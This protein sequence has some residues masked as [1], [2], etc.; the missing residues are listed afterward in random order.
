MYMV[1]KLW[2]AMRGMLQAYGGHDIKRHLWN[3]EFS[4]GRW[5]C[6][7]TSSDDRVYSYVEK[8]ANNGSILDLGCGSGSTGNELD[9]SAYREY[10][11]VD[12][13]DVAIDKAR[14]RSEANGRTSKNFYFQSDIASFVPSKK[15]DVILL[16]DSIYYLP[17]TKIYAVL[18]RYSSY[19][20]DSGVFIVRMHDYVSGNY[21]TIVD[22][23]ETNFT[24]HEK[25]ME[26]QS[27]M[28]IIVFREK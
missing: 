1:Q 25:Y 4:K 15:F 17:G 18:H 20:N 14:R 13:S 12:I 10:I 16:R 7:D 19:L 26:D 27:T 24:V 21:K 22:I 8:Y 23:L 28:L 2:N 6:L 3:S 9:Q 11:G 5:D